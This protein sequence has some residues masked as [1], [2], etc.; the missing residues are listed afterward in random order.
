MIRALLLALVLALPLPAR[1]QGEE[2]RAQA[3]RLMGFFVEGGVN[4]FLDALLAE[5]P[6][7]GN[8]LARRNVGE[9]RARW[10]REF[11]AFGIVIDQVYAGERHYAPVFRTL[12]YVIRYRR[13]PLFVSL[14]YYQ[15]PRQ[16]ELLTYAW[17]DN[18]ANWEC[19]PG[20]PLIP[21]R[22]ESPR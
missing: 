22:Q 6:L 9:N 16:W 14:R 11:E 2:P 15:T 13:Q 12:C 8:A 17:Q 10:T 7:G 19:A 20:A 1:A 4:G 21:P 18:V 5:T 3:D